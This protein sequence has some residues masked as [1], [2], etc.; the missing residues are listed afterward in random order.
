MECRQKP[1]CLL[2]CGADTCSGVPPRVVCGAE[3]SPGD[4]LAPVWAP[5]LHTGSSS[6]PQ[7]LRTFTWKA[8]L[9]G[10]DAPGRAHCSFCNSL[11]LFSERFSSPRQTTF[12]GLGLYL[13][14][15]FCIVLDI[16][17]WGVGGERETLTW[18]V[19]TQCP[20]A[21]CIGC[22]R[23]PYSSLTTGFLSF[24]FLKLWKDILTDQLK[25]LSRLYVI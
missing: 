6:S 4:R 17:D 10:E 9:R 23:W 16:F 19:G 3:W 13:E 18:M 14:L 7:V 5:E 2:P 25:H 22:L 11:R 8:L 15:P 24:D 21:N 1:W 20:R 12:L